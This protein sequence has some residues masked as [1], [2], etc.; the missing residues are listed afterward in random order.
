LSIRQKALGISGLS[1][2]LS[3]LIAAAGVWGVIQ[4]TGR[5]DKSAVGA[6]AIRRHTAAEMLREGLLAD[7]YRGLLAAER[8]DTAELDTVR[9]D[10]TDH[11]AVFRAEIAENH[12]LPLPPEVKA[13]LHALAAPLEASARATSTQVLEAA[14]RLAQPSDDMHRFVETFLARVRAA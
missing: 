6:R 3:L 10:V 12:G 9:Q 5:M 2:M 11:A 7:V 1:K 4:V 13:A 8:R 14:R